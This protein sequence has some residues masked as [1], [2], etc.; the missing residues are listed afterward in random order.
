MRS[1]LSI[2]LRDGKP[3]RRWGLALS[4]LILA[5]VSVT[6]AT[7]PVAARAATLTCNQTWQIVSSPNP[8][9]S[10]DDL[11]GVASVSATDA[12]AV[13]GAGNAPFITRWDGN[14][15]TQV[16]VPQVGYADVLYAVAASSDTNAWAV[17]YYAPSATGPSFTLTYHW[18]GSSWS[19]IPSPNGGTDTNN[20]VAVT[21]GH[22]TF[23]VGYSITNPNYA[24]LALRYTSQGWVRTPTPNLGTFGQMDLTGVGGM[25]DGTALAVGTGETF[26]GG[27][28]ANVL[29]WD[30]HSWSV[31]ESP[32]FPDDS[33]AALSVAPS[34]SEAMAVGIDSSS[35]PFSAHRS[36]SGT[37][38]TSTVTLPAGR[39]GGLLGVAS[40]RPGAWAVGWTSPADYSSQIALTAR[41][42][43][44]TWH[45]V[46]SPNPS[47]GT[48]ASLSSVSSAGGTTWA[49]GG[50]RGGAGR[51]PNTDRGVLL[52]GLSG[53]AIRRSGR[54]RYHRRR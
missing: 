19:Y 32:Q 50:Y 46:P 51:V 53:R 7:R 39:V 15:W 49:V 3:G 41:W 52:G 5:A 10:G 2:V 14:S 16:S 23:A 47:H 34:T 4:A 27:S 17:G 31:L 8:S 22:G 45:V 35:A 44:T 42:D 54:V 40:V 37:W 9:G 24:T 12:W 1:R 48:Q 25:S 28:I 43:G 13:G 20:L 11:S 6:T 21:T 36:S 33:L 30:G 29:S 26:G 38:S 18:D